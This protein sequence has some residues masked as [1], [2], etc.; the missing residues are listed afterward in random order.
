LVSAVPAGTPVSDAPGKP[1]VLTAGM[2]LA[3]GLGGGDGGRLALTV[4]LGEGLGDGLG[5][6]RAR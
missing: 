2:V 6:G 4:L 1:V 3:F 5:L